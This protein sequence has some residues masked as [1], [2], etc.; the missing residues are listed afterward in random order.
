MEVS[1]HR[2]RPDW[3]EIVATTLAMLACT[4]LLLVPGFFVPHY[5]AVVGVV[6]VALMAFPLVRT[7]G[8]CIAGLRR[9]PEPPAKPDG[10]EWPR[11]T[12]LI[13]TY[14][15]ANV[16]P[17]SMAAL[18]HVDYPRDRIEFLYVCES[19][20]NDGTQQLLRDQAERDPRFRVF[21]RSGGRPG[22]SAAFN[23][24]VAQCHG[25][26]LVGLDADQVLKPDAVQRAARWFL[27]D[28]K[29]DCI[30]GRAI[31]LN[32]RESP[33]A[34]MMRI[35][36]DILER[37]D[38]YARQLASGFTFFGGGQVFFRRSVFDRVGGY[39]EEQ[40]VEDIDYSVRIHASGGRLR[41][42][43]GIQTHEENP[44]RLA[45]WWAQRKRWARGWF[46]VAAHYLPRIHRL[47]VRA[48]P[49]LDLYLTFVYV[50]IP[51]ALILLLPLGI[52]G[53]FGYDVGALPSQWTWIWT[54]AAV[55]PFVSWATMMVRDAIDGVR[56]EWREVAALPFLPVYY[57]MLSIV[58]WAAFFDEF[59]LR[60]P[61]VFV[62]TSKTGAQMGGGGVA[63][64]RV[65]DAVDEA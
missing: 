39:S 50:F 14:N 33:L 51:M 25:D 30:K 49:R 32:G 59:V 11:V 34:L 12:I 64:G 9:N 37:G 3:G 54:A 24:G 27:A 29:L 28:P 45:A 4:L 43:P 40:L 44:A 31:G 60:K 17:R 52:L 62:K 61:R 19:R 20:S 41:V 1:L 57:T 36:R 2:D 35:E 56:H 16:L 7:Y 47:R 10:A 13:P 63:A 21:E 38:I 58:A 8:S 46:Q 48:L 18:A 55:A 26:I 15:E 5:F 65:G 53:R 42:D 6:L 22:K 23:D